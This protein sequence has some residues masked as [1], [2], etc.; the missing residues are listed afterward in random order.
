MSV[1]VAVERVRGGPPRETWVAAGRGGV[2]AIHLGP[3]RKSFIASLARRGFVPGGSRSWVAS[4]LRQIRE[5]YAGRRRRFTFA[6]C[7]DPMAQFSSRVVDCLRRV[8]YGT[9]V[10]YG[11]LARRAGSPRASR[12]VGNLMASNQLP[13]VIPCHRVVAIR[14]LGGFGGGLRMKRDLLRLEGARL[15]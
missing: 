12:A 4:A 15:P 7:P 6:I 13:L 8:T 3:G 2:V 14:G 5:Y 1:R 10:T 11:E 9:T